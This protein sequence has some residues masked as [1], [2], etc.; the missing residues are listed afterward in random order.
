MV[1]DKQGAGALAAGGLAAVLASACCVG[2]LVLVSV[3]LGGAWLS[4]LQVL[5][6][7]QPVFIGIA[8]VALF[9]AYRRIF[10]PA[11]ACAP[12]EVCAIPRVIRAY[13]ILFWFVAVLVLI[14]FGFPYLAPYFY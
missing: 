12:G 13:K 8:L 6:P 1:G 7:Y 4:N 9:F 5:A 11:T 2:P 14:A 3:G 10:R